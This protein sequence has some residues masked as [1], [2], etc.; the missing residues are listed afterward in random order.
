M[1]APAARRGRAGTLT[2][3]SHTDFTIVPYELYVTLAE[4]LYELTPIARRAEGGVL[5]RGHRGGR[6]RDQVRP[7]APGS[8]P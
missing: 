5:Q 1:L 2:R 8:P 4:R 6:E 7:R 3:F